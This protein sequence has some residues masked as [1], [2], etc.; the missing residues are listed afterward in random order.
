MVTY[1]FH[2]LHCH[3]LLPCTST[4][5]TCHTWE[6][7]MLWLFSWIWFQYPFLTIYINLNEWQEEI[8]I[9][10]CIFFLQYCSSLTSLRSS[11]K[12]LYKLTTDDSVP[13]LSCHQS[14]FRNGT[15]VQLAIRISFV[16]FTTGLPS[17]TSI[18]LKINE[19]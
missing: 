9:D 11:E 3:L 19:L 18:W 6:K 13:R 5:S 17:S 4:C 2:W 12:L 14:C 7:V 10:C 8:V 16:H 15:T 1:S